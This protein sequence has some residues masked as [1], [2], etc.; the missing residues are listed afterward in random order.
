[1]KTSE[2]KPQLAIVV[3]T[4]PEVIRFAPIIKALEKYTDVSIDILHTGQHYSQDMSQIFFDELHVKPPS[5]NLGVGS[6]EPAHQVANII[7]GCADYF[8]ST[9][10]EMVCIWGDT[11]S[12]LGAALAANKLK[13][14]VC[15]IE[16]GCRSFDYRMSEEYNRILIDHLADILFPLA[17]NDARNLTREKVPGRIVQAGD[18]LL[19]VF[20]ENTKQLPKNRLRKKLGL[21]HTKYCLLTLHR[22]ENTDDK[23]I[24]STILKKVGALK[25]HVVLFPMHPRTKKMLTEFGLLPLIDN[26]RFK[27][28]QPLSYL[29]LLEVLLAADFVIT[30]SGGLQKEAFFASKPCLTLRKSTEWTDTVKLGVNLLTDPQSLT[31][32][33]QVI[34]VNK[35]N[36]MKNRFARLKATPYGKGNAAQAIAKVIHQACFRTNTQS[37]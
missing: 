2:K 12:S 17:A 3:G 29:E 34:S 28:V 15:H 21:L 32:T 35:L 8:I 18:P 4:R 36:L 24:L 30:D 19:D 23:E 11:N 9:K 33:T 6:L 16:A 22:A 10:P 5:I 7:V 14:R 27:I 13:I 26:D 1:M 20:I 25:S 37:D 31:Q